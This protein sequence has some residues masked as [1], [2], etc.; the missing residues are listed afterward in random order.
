[1]NKTVM[2]RKIT[3][4]REYLYIGEKSKHTVE[5]YVR[6]ALAFCDFLNGREIGKTVVIQYKASLSM[7][8]TQFNLT[9]H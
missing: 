6:D 1:M 4:F 2:Y 8:L 7:K 9:R 3:K 5:K